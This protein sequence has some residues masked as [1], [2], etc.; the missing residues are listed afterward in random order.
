M[1]I[2]ITLL[3]NKM[4]TDFKEVALQFLKLVV[5]G[6]IDEAYEKYV[7]MKGKHHNVSFPSGFLAL[8]EAMKENHEKFPNK[9]F[10]VKNVLCEN[11]LVAVHSHVVLKP[12]ETEII[13]VHIFRIKNDRIVEMWDSGQLI[14]PSSP[15]KDGAF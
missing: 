4:K 3:K 15:N 11:D 14:P 10:T 13:A 9:K 7:D 8:K 6:K 2:I 5:A 12:K 1:F